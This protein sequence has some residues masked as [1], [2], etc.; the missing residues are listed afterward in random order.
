[1]ST[2]PPT[3]PRTRMF[4]RVMG[5]FLVIVTVTAIARTS[6]MRMLLTEFRANFVWPWVGGA[7][8]LL[9]GLVVVAL[10]RHWRGAPAIIV[11]AV[12]WMTTLKGFFLMAFPQTYLG[13][14]SDA[15]E[16]PAWWRGTFIVMALAGLYLTFI[17][18][19]PVPH[20]TNPQTA[21]PPKDLPRAA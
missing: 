2:P 1:M 17:G 18:W 12:G 10:H 14:A 3:P 7:F 13:F 15:I 20:R 8:T 21:T 5:P 9:T 16:A 6:E 4:A 11:S 19:A